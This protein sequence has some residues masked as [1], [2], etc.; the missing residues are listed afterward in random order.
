MELHIFIKPSIQPIEQLNVIQRAAL[1][2]GFLREIKKDE[3]NFAV[4]TIHC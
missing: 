1:F 2:P 3:A 4:D